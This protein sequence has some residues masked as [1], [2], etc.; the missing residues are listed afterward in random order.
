MGGENKTEHTDCLYFPVKHTKT[1]TKLTFSSYRVP[2]YK[3]FNLITVSSSILNSHRSS[4][5][6]N[7]TYVAN[8]VSHRLN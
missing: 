1:F 6:S 2:L 5:I 8:S 7:E 3:T 4:N